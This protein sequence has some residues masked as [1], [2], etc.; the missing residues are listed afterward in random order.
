MTT[1]TTYLEQELIQYTDP[2]IGRMGI[3]MVTGMMYRKMKGWRPTRKAN[4]TDIT[5]LMEAGV[6]TP[7]QGTNI[8]SKIYQSEK[9]EPPKVRGFIVVTKSGKPLQYSGLDEQEVKLLAKADGHRVRS[10][11]AMD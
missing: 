7:L 4:R 11:T 3:S 5:I 1:T 6:L 9:P 10:I 2:R 8:V